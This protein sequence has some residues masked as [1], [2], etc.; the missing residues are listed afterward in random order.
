MAALTDSRF[1]RSL[2]RFTLGSGTL[3]RGSDRV[4]LIGRIAV[5]L[6]FLAA[7]PLAVA[8]ATATNTRLEAV[9]AA[10]AAERHPSHAVLIADAPAGAASAGN[11][12]GQAGADDGRPA[13]VTARAVWSAP[14]EVLRQGWVVVRARTP[15]GTA[16]PVW[17]DAAGNLTE[18]PMSRSTVAGTAQGM[19]LLLLIGVPLAAWTCYA[20]LSWALDAYRDVQWAR[21][22]EALDRESGPQM[23]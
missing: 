11:D 8:A 12:Y 15:A 16:V 2:R 19:G 13:A 20:V 18:P 23:R 22:W 1:R 9:A 3:K 17:L 10:Q 21:G 7:P 14:G 6:A 4:Q 5:V